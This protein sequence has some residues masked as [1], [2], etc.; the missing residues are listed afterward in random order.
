MTTEGNTERTDDASPDGSKGWHVFISYAHQD[1]RSLVPGGVFDAV[2][3]KQSIEDALRRVNIEP[4]VFLDRYR[5]LPAQQWWP[6]ILQALGDAEVLLVVL[7]PAYLGRDYC[8][9]EWDEFRARPGGSDAVSV[10][11]PGIVATVASNPPEWLEALGRVQRFDSSDGTDSWVDE[12]ARH[13]VH[14]AELRRRVQSYP[15]TGALPSNRFVGRAAELELLA[16]AMAAPSAASRPVVLCGAPGM[17]KTQVALQYA[18]R[19]RHLF[20]GGVRVVDATRLDLQSDRGWLIGGASEPGDALVIVDGL[21]DRAAIAGLSGARLPSG[22]RLLVTTTLDPWANPDLAS[23]WIPVPP[24]L[25]ED[26]VRL[27]R[28]WQ[29][30]RGA[31]RVLDFATYEDMEL[32]RGLVSRLGGRPALLDRLGQYLGREDVP[33]A[34]LAAAL[35]PLN[36]DTLGQLA[37]TAAETAG[38]PMV[39]ALQRT[40]AA[41]AVDDVR[42]L[43]AASFLP[44]G[45][46]PRRWLPGLLPGGADPARLADLMLHW[47]VWGV[48]L[49]GQGPGD[50][51]VTV[52]PLLSEVVRGHLDPDEATAV[53][54][55]VRVQLEGAAL[56]GAEADAGEWRVIVEWASACAEGAVP[57]DLAARIDRQ[58]ADLMD[59]VPP[60]A[61]LRWTDT[62]LRRA[63][64]ELTSA[65]LKPPVVKFAM[66]ALMRSALVRAESD[67][68]QALAL[69]ELGLGLGTRLTPLVRRAPQADLLL[70][71]SRLLAADDPAKALQ[72]ATMAASL[73]GGLPLGASGAAEA[74]VRRVAL[75]ESIGVG[76]WE[77]HA[78]TAEGLVR[79]LAGAGV[80]RHVVA[81]LNSLAV[82]W[83]ELEPARAREL[84]REAHRLATPH[85]VPG[86]GNGWLRQAVRTAV[87]AAGLESD[88]GAAL[89]S[90]REVV[91][92]ASE[93][94][95][96]PAEWAG[97]LASCDIAA[98]WVVHGDPSV[99][100]DP[101][102]QPRALLQRAS[103]HLTELPDGPGRRNLATQLLRAE[104]ALDDSEQ[105]PL[106]DWR[107]RADTLV[108]QKAGAPHRELAL[109]LLSLGDRMLE[110]GADTDTVF[111]TWGSALGAARPGSLERHRALG[112]QSRLAC[113]DGRRRWL[114]V[115]R[116]YHQAQE[117]F[118]GARALL[119]RHAGSPAAFAAGVETL[120]TRTLVAP[121]GFVEDLDLLDAWA[122][123]H[124]RALVEDAAWRRRGVELLTREIRL[125]P[126]WTM[127]EKWRQAL[128]A[129][130]ATLSDGSA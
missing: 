32:V 70:L 106:G 4:R 31:R 69:V 121:S 71:R 93:P 88:H 80:P 97:E 33:L 24:L 10:H 26:A 114:S 74:A 40:V 13:V 79:G 124:A 52:D 65:P 129:A 72:D 22:L 128:R 87:V 126:E 95:R 122:K 46:V 27:V 81:G 55:Q 120:T 48:T 30:R 2:R 76:D 115:D 63:D 59:V 67:T 51:L 21:A 108:K 73:L 85:R 105:P 64:A 86:M 38:G 41:L 6:T 50:T 90:L 96:A 44:G 62:R 77:R 57:D 53:E 98:A 130:A 125:M 66:E 116:R 9:R 29:P 34:T 56:V 68:T 83:R 123:A 104:I 20:P 103:E 15:W 102:E 23:A 94:G 35:E 47:R 7:T 5:L 107:S 75:G 127:A 119:E 58:V 1:D 45:R 92:L 89:A 12:L 3:L 19:F 49:A 61:L 25:P 16:T 113:V 54:A 36:L 8:F 111:S 60:E 82:S 43:Q 17:G 109:L 28:Q 37:G 117:A 99:T 78:A 118:A 91:A 101:A 14:R 110:Q 11:Q 112:R 100:D 84:A 42:L 39:D 18:D